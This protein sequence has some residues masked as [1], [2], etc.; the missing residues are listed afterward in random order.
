VYGFSIRGIKGGA[1]ALPGTEVD[2]LGLEVDESGTL[3]GTGG[4][5]TVPGHKLRLDQ[6]CRKNLDGVMLDEFPLGHAC[7]FAIQG[8]IGHDL[9]R[10]AV[11]T[12]DF[13]AIRLLLASASA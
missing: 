2:S 11:L 5:G 9:L 12:L 13:S 8:L 6:L 7:G 3:V 10:E 4:G 1:F